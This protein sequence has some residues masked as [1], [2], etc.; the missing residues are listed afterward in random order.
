[1]ENKSY[2]KSLHKLT[3]EVTQ[4]PYIILFSLREENALFK[5]NIA[6]IMIF[7]VIDVIEYDRRNQFIPVHRGSFNNYVDKKRVVGVSGKST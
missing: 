6:C 3:L 4:L 5:S 1:M 2:N 7:F